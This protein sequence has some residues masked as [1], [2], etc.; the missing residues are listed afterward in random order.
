MKVLISGYMIGSPTRERAQCL[1][2]RP[3][4]NRS[5][6]TPGTP[7]KII[8]RLKSPLSSNDPRRNLTCDGNP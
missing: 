8:K 1:T 4:S 6:F 5:G 7:G 3:S 2:A